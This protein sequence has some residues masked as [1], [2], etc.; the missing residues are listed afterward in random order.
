MVTR[1]QEGLAQG[2]TGQSG[3]VQDVAFGANGLLCVDHALKILP[4]LPL[5][6]LIILH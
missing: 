6:S 3:S 4:V 1:S 5:P 2:R